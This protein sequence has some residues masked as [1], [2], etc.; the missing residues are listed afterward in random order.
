MSRQTKVTDLTREAFGIAFC[1]IFLKHPGEKIAIKQI[2]DMAGYNRTTFYRYFADVDA[3]ME[4]LEDMI[5]E[6]LEE[7]IEEH[8]TVKE[9]NDNFF[10]SLLEICRES[11]DE[12][13]VVLSERNRAHLIQKMRGTL[14]PMCQKIYDVD[15][16]NRRFQYIIDIYYS[17]VFSALWEWLEQPDYLTEE[18]FLWATKGLFSRWIL[19][20]LKVKANAQERRESIIPWQ[21]ECWREIG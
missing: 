20:E 16:K 9:M 19:P 6:A 1:R 14:D 7:K 10:E 3:I 4:Y 11:K 5:I 12:L 15:I 8:G 18:D 21:L 17:S 2:T 13:R